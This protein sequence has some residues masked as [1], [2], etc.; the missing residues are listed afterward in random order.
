MTKTGTQAVQRRDAPVQAQ[1]AEKITSVPWKPPVDDGRRAV[2]LSERHAAWDRPA[3][4]PEEPKA[5]L[6]DDEADVDVGALG[7]LP[8]KWTPDLVHCRLQV[9]AGIARQLPRPKLPPLW[10]SFLGEL[11]PQ[12]AAVAPRRVL[13]AMDVSLFDWTWERLFSWDDEDRATLLGVATGR[14]LKKIE[15]VIAGMAARQDGVK[16]VKK[17]AIHKRYWKFVALMA[18]EWNDAGVPVD[19]KTAALWLKASK[20]V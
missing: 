6:V 5:E 8:K 1:E 19:L 16:A 13:T 7:P 3:I 9:A 20:K 12:D 10:R 14:S 2:L 17:S 11:Q 4:K 18:A 15:A